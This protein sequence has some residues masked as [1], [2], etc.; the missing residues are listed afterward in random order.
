MIFI[1]EPPEER[2]AAHHLM[3]HILMFNY[4]EGNFGRLPFRLLEHVD[5]LISKADGARDDI[6]TMGSWG[7]IAAN[8]AA[9]TITNFRDTISAI[10]RA[11]GQCRSLLDRIDAKSLN[12]MLEKF[13]TAFPDYKGTRDGFAHF[14][15]QDV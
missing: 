7:L 1:E 3:L 8:Y 14:G 10:N 4:H 9:V 12:S 15:R 13:A 6:T 5:I 2:D 11:A